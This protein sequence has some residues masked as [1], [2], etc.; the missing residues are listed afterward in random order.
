[1]QVPL[2]YWT[3]RAVGHKPAQ[4]WALAHRTPVKACDGMRN[5]LV[6]SALRAKERRF[7]GEAI[8]GFGDL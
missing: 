7:S 4:A 2:I 6:R 3:L 1:M 8:T 5:A